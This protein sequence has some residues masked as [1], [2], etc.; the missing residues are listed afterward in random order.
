MKE[1]I[2]YPSFSEK[3]DFC[4]EVG[5]KTIRGNDD[6]NCKTPEVVFCEEHFNELKI[7]TRK[8]K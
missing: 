4:G 5:I 1:I 6:L 2:Q 3:C 8:E 7:E